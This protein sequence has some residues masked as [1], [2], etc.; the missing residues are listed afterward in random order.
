MIDNPA[1]PA[2]MY[3]EEE[4]SAHQSAE[5][6]AMAVAVTS[7]IILFFAVISI[8]IVG[9]ELFGVLQLAYFNL[10]DNEYVNLYLSPLL[11]WRFLN[12]F[13]LALEKGSPVPESILAIDY[14]ISFISNINVMFLLLIC[15][16]I[17]GL[18]LHFV[19]AKV[20]FL[21]KVSKF[22][23]QEVFLTLF[24]FSSFNIAFSAGL[25]FKYATP[26]STQYYELSTLAAV[27]G[28]LTYLI[29][30]FCFQFAEKQDFGEFK[31]KFKKDC[32]NQLYISFS[33]IYRMALGLYMATSI[34][35]TFGTLIILAFS[36]TYIMYNIVNLPFAD[37]YQNYRANLCHVTQLIVLLA[38]NYYRSMRFNDPL[39]TRRTH[40][41]TKLELA[42]I[43]IGV[44]VSAVCLAY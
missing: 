8:K 6:L 31:Q 27:L 38:T 4:C 16:L 35:D 36:L 5:K 22:M 44:V 15:E 29:I 12:G 26:A 9:L 43:T 25:H 34:E 37:F 11:N 24:L 42:M 30:L 32:I 3:S 19:G 33:V 39:E 7:Y 28:V 17:L 10:A 14:G 13:N 20:A 18:L 40:G 1:V 41:L 2:V 21:K 23:L